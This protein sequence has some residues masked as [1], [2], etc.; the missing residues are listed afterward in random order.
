MV[1]LAKTAT[2]DWKEP[3]EVILAPSCYFSLN[4]CF[5]GFA[6]LRLA[7]YRAHGARAQVPIFTPHK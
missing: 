3:A 5:D 7:L 6:L 1:F 4:S 2:Q